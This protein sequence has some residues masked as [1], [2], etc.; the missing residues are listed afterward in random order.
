MHF[1]RAGVAGKAYVNAMEAGSS[2]LSMYAHAEAR[3]FF[4]MAERTA[5]SIDERAAAL[6]RLAEVAETEG[7]YAL[8]EELCDRALAGLAGRPEDATTLALRRMRQR[9]R[10]LQGQPAAETIAACREL[11]DMARSLNDRSEEAALLNMISLYQGRL[12]EWREA[13]SIARE[14]VEAAENANNDR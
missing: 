5:T 1:D 4:E 11:L 3:R 13:E 7:R 12:G 10:A 14:A 8:T 2:A 6:H 9:T